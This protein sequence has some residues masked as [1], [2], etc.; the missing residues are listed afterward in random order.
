[1]KHIPS[2]VVQSIAAAAIQTWLATRA[3]LPIAIS[4]INVNAIYHIMNLPT[5]NRVLDVWIIVCLAKMKVTVFYVSQAQEINQ[6]TVLATLGSMKPIWLTVCLVQ[7]IVWVAQQVRFV[8][9]A[10]SLIETLR[11]NVSATPHSG[12]TMALVWAV[13]INVPTVRTQTELVSLV[14]VRFR[15]TC[16]IHA[17]AMCLAT[18]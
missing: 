9:N 12:T 11:I 3:L 13:L 10:S 6:P 4:R 18:T 2:N 1:M 16:L 14:A 15:E 5:T 17:I 7:L 8:S